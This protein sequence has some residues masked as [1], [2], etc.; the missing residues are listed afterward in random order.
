MLL[1]LKPE[2]MY[3]SKIVIPIERIF[4]IWAAGCA[5]NVNYNNG[6]LVEIEGNYVPKVETVHIV[7]D[8]SDEVDKVMRQFYKAVNS[9]SKAFYFGKD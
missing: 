5:V 9:N 4:D 3:A 2:K 6:E 7:F 8:D 1:F